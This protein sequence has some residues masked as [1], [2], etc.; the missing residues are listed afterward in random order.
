M[1]RRSNRN[2]EC[3]R[4]G[5]VKRR[6]A[7]AF[8]YHGNHAIE[9]QG[10]LSLCSNGAGTSGKLA[11]KDTNKRFHTLPQ[12]K[13]RLVEAFPWQA[14]ACGRGSLE[15]FLGSIGTT[16]DSPDS[17]ARQSTC[18]V[19][20]P[21]LPSSTPS[22][23][24][25]TSSQALDRVLA[26]RSW[27]TTG[28]AVGPLLSTLDP[29]QDVFVEV[30]VRVKSLRAADKAAAKAT[31]AGFQS[32]PV[33]RDRQHSTVVSS[34]RSP[35]CPFSSHPPPSASATWRQAHS[36]SPPSTAERNKHLC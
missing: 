18:T 13:E 35:R 3:C 31:A 6:V 1:C 26:E 27:Y 8:V 19:A 11:P 23:F 32:L 30:T 20:G 17:R 9:L 14:G 28:I 34:T 7:K 25:G 33:P 16:I 10:S 5:L 15:R 24:Q 12:K 4:D 36:P 22:T 29:R 2:R 21:R